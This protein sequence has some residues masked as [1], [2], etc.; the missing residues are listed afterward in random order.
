MGKYHVT[1]LCCS[2]HSNRQ[3]FHSLPSSILPAGITSLFIYS[4]IQH[5]LSPSLFI[6]PKVSDKPYLL[7]TPKNRKQLLT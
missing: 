1:L 5:K 6:L 7:P 2:P 3:I 4:T